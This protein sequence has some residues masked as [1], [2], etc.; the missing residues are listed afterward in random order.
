MVSRICFSKTQW[1]WGSR[2]ESELKYGWTKTL[3]LIIIEVKQWVH[4]LYYQSLLMCMFE[5]FQ[6]KTFCIMQK[7]EASVSSS[8][9]AKSSIL[10]KDIL[11]SFSPCFAQILLGFQ[12]PWE[13]SSTTL[14]PPA[15]GRWTKISSWPQM[16]SQLPQSDPVS[17]FFPGT[18][19]LDVAAIK[20]TGIVWLAPLEQ[21]FPILTLSAIWPGC[22][23]ELQITAEQE[24]HRLQ[25]VLSDSWTKCSWGIES[26]QGK[27]YTNITDH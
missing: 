17:I 11:C 4:M 23:Q 7:V 20:A 8:S 21:V 22:F 1:S 19:F 26:H 15:A 5:I 14:P 9:S 2:Y 3:E 6:D 25:W 27:W 10:L 16:A 13:W 12:T 18:W 24:F